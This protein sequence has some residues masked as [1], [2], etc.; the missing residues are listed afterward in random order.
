MKESRRDC[1]KQM[2]L[3][4]ASLFAAAGSEKGGAEAQ[5]GAPSPVDDP[6]AATRD[7]RMAWWR[8]ARFGMFMHFGLYSV[9]SRGEWLMAVEDIPASEYAKFANDFHPAPGSTRGWA[10]AARDA[11]MKYVVLT[12]KH[13]EGFC[14]FDTKLT[15]YC[16]TKMGPKRDIIAEY[17]ESVRA[18][19]LK[20]GFYFSL[21]DWRHPDGMRCAEDEAAR[22]R[23]VEFVHGQVRELMTNYGKIDILWYDMAYPL[24]ARGF[25]SD[26]LNRMVLGLQPSIVVNNRSGMPG[27]FDTPEQNTNPGKRDWES[28]MT[29]NDNWG[30]AHADHNWKSVGTVVSNLVKCSMYGGNYLLDVGPTPEGPLPDEC[31]KRLHEV[32]EWMRHYGESIYGSRRSAVGYSSFGQFTQ[33]GNTV[34][35]H[36]DEWIGT[37][38]VLAGIKARLKSARFL[39]SGKP[40]RF[41][42]DASQIVLKDL[43]PEPPYT[44]GPVIALEFAEPPV[45]DTMATRIVYKC[46]PDLKPPEAKA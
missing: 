6:L 14:L 2:L 10:R 28:C 23:F 18:E 38:M 29:L 31:L 1:L 46:L 34:Y 33:R 41:E 3:S 4:G 43:P 25:E 37:E 7:Q 42:Q 27:D 45:Q 17:V 36:V 16:A 32:G 5:A 30:Y 44:P 19:G 12:T 22:R 15:D 11:G 20:V 39:D 9:P 13:H 24:D 40:V 8:D 35:A 26:R 21:M